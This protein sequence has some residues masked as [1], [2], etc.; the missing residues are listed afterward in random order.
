MVTESPRAAARASDDLLGQVR[1]LRQDADFM[2]A[3]A[4][5]L[6]SAAATLDGCPAAP[7]WSRATLE[8]Q[9][10]ACVTAAEQLRTAAEALL[11]HARG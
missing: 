6:L 10:A 11:T 2:G 7:E 4:R 8:Q 9:A 5:Q 1:T 3:Y